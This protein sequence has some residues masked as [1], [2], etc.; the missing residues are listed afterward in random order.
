MTELVDR[1][2]VDIIVIDRGFAPARGSATREVSRITLVNNGLG[3]VFVHDLIFEAEDVGINFRPIR[4]PLNAFIAEGNGLTETIGR[5]KAPAHYVNLSLTSAKERV[6]ILQM[7]TAEIYQCFRLEIADA[8]LDGAPLSQQAS[9]II[10]TIPIQAKAT[11][12]STRTHDQRVHRLKK[13]L[14]AAILYDE[15]CNTRITTP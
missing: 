6:Q 9:A 12:V 10:G 5:R 15:T 3:P 8:A 14:R 13:P 2:A 11:L 4:L 1:R 7:Q